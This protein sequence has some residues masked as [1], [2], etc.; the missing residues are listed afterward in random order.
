[1][2][3]S[4][5]YP[6]VLINRL[7]SLGDN[8]FSA[9]YMST[10]P[11]RIMRNTPHPIESLGTSPLFLAKKEKLCSF[12]WLECVNK[13]EFPPLFG[14]DPTAHSLPSNPNWIE[15][16]KLTLFERQHFALY[17][18]AVLPTSYQYGLLEET[19]AARIQIQYEAENLLEEYENFKN[20][21]LK[22]GEDATMDEV[23]GKGEMD[24]TNKALKQTEFELKPSTFSSN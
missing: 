16:L 1:M 12:D 5:V 21:G 19:S 7:R 17:Q 9:W 11:S 14:E 3:S 18:A 22:F 15:E 2:C 10:L 20:Q 13:P 4:V 6:Y 24:E 23:H 8:L